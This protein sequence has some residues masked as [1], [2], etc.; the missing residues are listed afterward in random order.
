MSA[1]GRSETL[2]G[3]ASFLEFVLGRDRGMGEG[4]GKLSRA[5]LGQV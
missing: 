1:E 5:S 2:E 4:E 3:T